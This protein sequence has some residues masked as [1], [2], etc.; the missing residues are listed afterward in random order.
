MNYLPYF[1]E[2][3]Q[4]YDGGLDDYIVHNI[5]R[6][7]FEQ[8]GYTTI[9]FENVHWD[10]SDSDVFY[11]FGFDI[12]SPFMRPFEYTFLMN[13]MFKALIELNT[14]T[15]H[16][17]SNLLSSPVKQHYL[18]QSKILDEF[19]NKAIDLESPKFV[20]THIENPHGPY[21]FDEDGSF[22]VEDAYYRDKYFSAIN[23]DYAKEGY[24]KQVKFIN[25]RIKPIIENIL[26]S[27]EQQPVIILQSDHSNEESEDPVDRMKILLAIYLPDNDFS[28]LYDSI[29]PINIYRIIFDQYFDESL[30]LIKDRSFFSDR[31][32]RYDLIEVFEDNELCK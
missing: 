7:K 6:T 15:Q 2:E 20:F 30:N 31:S 22:Q 24:I 32:D 16:Y 13:S 18:L 19:E 4:F 27:S 23:E 10:Y 26:T 1:A 9:S 17:F 14:T 29:S 21:V 3:D 11:K 8:F 5:V 28:K 25:E 12:F